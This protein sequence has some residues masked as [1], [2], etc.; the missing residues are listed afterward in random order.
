MMYMKHCF[1]FFLVKFTIDKLFFGHQ[2]V[3]CQRAFL[4]YHCCSLSVIMVQLK[5]PFLD[6]EILQ[7]KKIVKK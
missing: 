3:Q 4:S 2:I 5:W 1:L 7:H 6:M